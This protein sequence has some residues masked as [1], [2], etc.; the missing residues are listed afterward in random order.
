MPDD[1]NPDDLFETW[2]I[3]LSPLWGPFYAIFYIM[4]LLWREFRNR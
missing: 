1:F 3:R 4:R 2:V